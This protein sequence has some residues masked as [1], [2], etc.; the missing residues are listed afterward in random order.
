MRGEAKK[1]A[2][3]DSPT[4][5]KPKPVPTNIPC[6]ECGEP[7]LIRT[8]RTGPFLGCSKYPKCKATKP[9]PQGETA[10]SLA[11]TGA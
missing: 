8:G 10:E 11:A 9:M 1:R 3:A 7:M 4:P 6:D 5:A 2:E